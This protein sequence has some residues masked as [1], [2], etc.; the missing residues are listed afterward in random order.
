MREGK[1]KRGQAALILKASLKVLL[2]KSRKTGRSKT[3]KNILIECLIIIY[4]GRIGAS[5][6]EKWQ[7]CKLASK[8]ARKTAREQEGKRASETV[9]KRGRLHAKTSIASKHRP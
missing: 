8:K 5:T 7:A 9:S 4:R 6:A 2:K 3:T 1:G